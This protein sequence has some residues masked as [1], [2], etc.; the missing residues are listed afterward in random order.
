MKWRCAMTGI[1][2][3]VAGCGE[4][5]SSD[6]TGGE[7]PKKPEVRYLAGREIWPNDQP[8][9]YFSAINGVLAW[10]GNTGFPSTGLVHAL[11]EHTVS[12]IGLTGRADSLVVV[13]P[14]PPIKG[15]LALPNGQGSYSVAIG[16]GASFRD[17]ILTTGPFN[18]PTMAAAECRPG[19]LSDSLSIRVTPQGTIIGLSKGALYKVPCPKRSNDYLVPEQKFALMPRPLSMI[20]AMEYSASD[21]SSFLLRYNDIIR[22]QRKLPIEIAIDSVASTLTESPAERLTFVKDRIEE[23]NTRVATEVFRFIGYTDTKDSNRALAVMSD[24]VSCD[25]CV[26]PIISTSGELLGTRITMRHTW[27]LAHPLMFHEL[28]HVLGFY[29]SCSV[30]SVQ[31]GFGCKQVHA[32][33][34]EDIAWIRYY[35]VDLRRLRETD[36]VSVPLTNQAA[37][38]WEL[39]FALRQAR[40]LAK[41]VNVGANE[42]FPFTKD[43]FRIEVVQPTKR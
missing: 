21:G 18:V 31:N 9:D 33:T 36:G 15:V 27:Q 29:H 30:L 26:I 38:Q 34:S 10:D 5:G 25:F 3:M 42:V 24:T 32:L 7:P 28:L 43:D 11:G 12:S 22:E 17:S 2:L 16:F 13:K 41:T 40:I 39:A 20:D 14:F 19:N 4:S 37:H 8:R 6:I 23:F 35:H 1:L